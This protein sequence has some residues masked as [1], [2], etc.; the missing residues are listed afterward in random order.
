MIHYDDSNWLQKPE[1]HRSFLSLSDMSALTCLSFLSS[2]NFP[3][4]LVQVFG[5]ELNRKKAVNSASS[6]FKTPGSQGAAMQS[7]LLAWFEN[8]GFTEK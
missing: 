6:A 5:S 3:M 1:S 4:C 2:V 7:Q 8:T